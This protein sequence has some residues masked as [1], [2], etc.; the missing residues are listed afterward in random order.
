MKLNFD[1]KKHLNYKQ[2]FTVAVD[3]VDYRE[4]LKPG[5]VMQYFQDLATTHAAILGLGYDV[6]LAQ[7]LC[8]VMSAMSFRAAKYPRLGDV[9]TAV[10]FPQKPRYA[11]AVRDCYIL[12]GDG[13]VMIGGTSKWCLLDITTRAV[14]GC[15]HMFG[16]GEDE[17]FSSVPVEGGCRKV[18]AVSGFEA[19]DVKKA[20]YAVRITDLDRN[21]HMNNA[22]YGDVVLDTCAMDELNRRTIKR[23]DINFL[24]EL[25]AGERFAVQKAD[26]GNE[27]YFEAAKAGDGG[28]VFR[29]VIGWE[30]L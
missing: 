23:F 3:E 24:S 9:I 6:M 28:A 8:W 5:A 20:E 19:S 11:A 22:R 17:Y 15:A 2:N 29:A 4:I 18:G 7:N 12:N 27:S 26:A 30:P 1:A 21:R 14:K 16:Y 13:D 25:F 10:T